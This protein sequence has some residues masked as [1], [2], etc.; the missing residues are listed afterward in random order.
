MVRILVADDDK[1]IRFFLRKVLEEKN[2]EVEVVESGSEVLRKIVK[3]KFDLLFLDIHMGGMGGLETIPL[4]KEIDPHLPIVVI[5]G[6]CSV[7]MKNRIQ[8]L[9]IFEYLTKP[10]DSLKVQD[11]AKSALSSK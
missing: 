9:G 2:Y 3:Q 5:T 6:D 11:V 1:F 8:S 7:E 10:L 4:V